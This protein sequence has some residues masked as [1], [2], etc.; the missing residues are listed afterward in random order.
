MNVF[1]GGRRIA[2]TIAFLGIVFTFAIGI[3]G[4]AAGRVY[5][6]VLNPGAAPIIVDECGYDSDAGERSR[7]R[8]T[9]R[10]VKYSLILCF[11]ASRSNNGKML[12]PYADRGDDV[13]LM[14][15]RFDDSV[16]RY[17]DQTIDALPVQPNE[18]SDAEK[19]YYAQVW[20]KWAG[21]AGWLL[22][23]LFGFFVFVSIVGWIVRGFMGIPSGHDCKP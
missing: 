4:S 18:I 8:V 11:P 16:E 19:S 3:E 13:W 6:R 12:I 15:T 21:G 10:G 17:M 9:P 20:R 7:Q 5:Y 14:N 1:S 22:L 2:A 23:S